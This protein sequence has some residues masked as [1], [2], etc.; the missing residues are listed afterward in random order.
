MIPIKKWVKCLLIC[1]DEEF[2]RMLDAY[3]EHVKEREALGIPPLPLNA[4]QT[5]LL[6]ALLKNPPQGEEDFLLHLLEHRIAPGV[7]EAAYVKAGFLA[8]GS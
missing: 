3:R 4:E 1:I 5:N 6:I 7:D 8:G 2:N